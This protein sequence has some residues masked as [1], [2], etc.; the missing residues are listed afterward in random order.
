M[1]GVAL[2]NSQDWSLV[3]RPEYSTTYND[4]LVRLG[5]AVSISPS[6]SSTDNLDPA[7]E[8]PAYQRIDL[9]ASLTPSSEAWEI[10]LYVHDLTDERRKWFGTTDFQSQSLDQTIFD[11]GGT[12]RDRGRRVG[13]Q[14]RYNF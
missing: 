6:F 7:R 12:S 9:R 11:G 14:A 1:Q 13:M 2:G 4:F 5:A 3:L 8:V 10:A